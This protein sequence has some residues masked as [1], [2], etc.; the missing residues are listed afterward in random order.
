MH[1][2]APRVAPGEKCPGARHGTNAEYHVDGLTLSEGGCLFH[3]RQQHIPGR[4][5][6][7]IRRGLQTKHAVTLSHVSDQAEWMM[8][9]PLG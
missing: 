8:L 9:L 3:L 2:A 6:P 1:R 7:F 4:L 5:F